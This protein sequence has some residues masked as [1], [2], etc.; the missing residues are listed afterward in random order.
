M[1][2]LLAPQ[3]DL[4]APKMA[5]AVP[6]HD[7]VSNPD[8]TWRHILD[9]GS[10]KHPREILADLKFATYDH[11]LA[12]AYPCGRPSSDACTSQRCSAVA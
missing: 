12:A 6:E 3:G 2:I 5:I 11:A 8:R 4:T 7:P 9:A 10:R 1:G